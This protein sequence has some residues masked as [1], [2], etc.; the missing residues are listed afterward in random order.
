MA[1][2]MPAL[3]IQPR[4]GA[5]PTRV[6]IAHHASPNCGPRRGGLV[7]RY[8]VLHHTAMASA[9]AAI[10]RLSDPAAE[11]SAHYV[12]CKSGAVTRLVD[13]DQRAWHAGVGEWCG[14]QDMNS[15][16]IGIELDNDAKAAFTEPLMQSLLALLPQVLARWDIP[17]ENV[18]GHS[19][20]APGRKIDPGAHFDWPRLAAGG[21][22]Q[23]Y[24]HQPAIDS[25]ADHGVDPATFRAAARHAGYTAD[26]DDAALLRAV[27]LRW[28][29][30]ATGR[31]TKAD[32][33]ALP[34]RP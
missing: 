23:P 32:L 33:S 22:A 17:A 30:K 11:V 21:L 20:M 15:R 6:Q 24:P 18:I 28:R 25:G 16:S 9:A 1:M 26:V 14:L 2:A 3:G 13:E 5:F 34:P 7:P 29:P 31:L 27:R 4:F 12:I 19:D 10:A 8:V